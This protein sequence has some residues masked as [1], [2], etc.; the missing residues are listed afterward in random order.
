MEIILVEL[1]QDV[2]VFMPKETGKCFTTNEIFLAHHSIHKITEPLGTIPTSIHFLVKLEKHISFL[3]FSCQ[4]ILELWRTLTTNVFVLCS[5]KERIRCTRN[6]PSPTVAFCH[7]I[8][9]PIR[10]RQ[11]ARSEKI[12][13]PRAARL[14]SL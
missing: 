7:R 13:S 8:H 3:S 14:E 2:E 1:S 12:T 4:L 11:T 9:N 10:D 6:Q 5:V